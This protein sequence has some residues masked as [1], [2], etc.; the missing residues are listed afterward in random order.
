M[1]CKYIYICIYKCVYIYMYLQFT[2]DTLLSRGYLGIKHTSCLFLNS[3]RSVTHS[4]SQ[5]LV[6]YTRNSWR[7]SPTISPCQAQHSF[8]RDSLYLN[9]SFFRYKLFYNFNFTLKSQFSCEFNNFFILTISISETVN[10]GT[11]H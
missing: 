10:S 9:P 4:L 6:V 8:N 3:R 11:D 5:S 7:G 2:R 1:L